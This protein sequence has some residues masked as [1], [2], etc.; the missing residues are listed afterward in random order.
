MERIVH[1]AP[2]QGYTDRIYRNVH[3]QVFGGVE[4]YYTPFVRIEKG[5]I[6]NKDL[7]D[8]AFVE[9]NPERVVP[10]LIAAV[11]DE[12]R[13]VAEEFCRQGYKRADINLGCPFPMQARQ[14]RGAGILP[15]ADEVAAI[16]D[17]MKEFP[18]IRFSA[19]LRLGWS[20]PDEAFALLPLLHEYPLTHIT[21]HP[22]IGVQQYKGKVDLDGFNR[23]HE[24]CRFPLFYNGDLQSET[25]IVSITTRFP[26]L[27]GVMLGRG[28]LAFPWLA[29]GYVTGSP[30]LQ[31][32][33][34]EKLRVFHSLLLQNYSEH[35]EG[36]EHQILGK[37]KTLWDYLLPDAE[38]KLHKKIIKSKNLPEYKQAVETLFSFY[39]IS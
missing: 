24:A 12:F 38:K 16:L 11:P 37:L 36:G 32:E 20:S 26:R 28:L 2:L 15:Y 35:L 4:T 14:H 34:R 8:I 22:R 21:L 18:D 17:V 30:L 7:R 27:Q 23:F 25:D 6:R 33:K 10:Q 1:F 19:K 3:A 29:G 13:Q 39:R 5:L 31:E 9:N